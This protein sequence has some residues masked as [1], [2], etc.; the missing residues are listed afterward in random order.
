MAKIL[1]E[2]GELRNAFAPSE[3]ELFCKYLHAESFDPSSALMRRGEPSDHMFFVLSGLV[4]VLNGEIQLAIHHPGDFIGESFL[5]EEAIRIADVHA[6]QDEVAVARFS[7]QDF[8]DFLNE[9]Q[10]LALKFRAYF[11][12]IRKIRDAQNQAESFRDSR[13]YL[14]LV[15]HNNMK[16]SLIKFC[17]YQI[18]K[19]SKFP[20][21][22]TGTTGS[23]LYKKTGLSLSKK[24]SSGPLGGDQAIGTLISTDNI[25]G[26]IFFRDPLSSHPH[27]ADIEALGRLCDVYQI[28]FATNPRS[29]EGILDYLLSDKCDNNL[30]PNHILAL[31]RQGQSK[32]AESL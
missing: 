10:E 9:D 26:V 24:V 31:Y 2:K 12:A 6:M 23:M 32:V 5:G 8:Q 21:V 17:E 15:A 30:I 16:N 13:K 20:L 14:A 22:A 25:C 28:P 29:A 3:I 7:I 27:H 1:Q 19:L 18:S 4:Q 11:N